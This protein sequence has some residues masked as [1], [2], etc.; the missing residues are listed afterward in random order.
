[1]PEDDSRIEEEFMAVERIL[2]PLDGSLTAE[3][4]LP[5]VRRLLRREDSELILVRAVVP[6]PVEHAALMVEAA[7]KA[8]EEYLEGIRARFEKAGVDAE[9]VVRLGSPGSVILDVARERKATLVAIATHGSSGVKRLLLGSVAED[10]VRHSPVPILAVR[11]FFEYSLAA[12]D[13]GEFDPVGTILF[14]VDEV[15]LAAIAIAPVSRLAEMFES[16]VT[17]VKVL[18]SKG[19]KPASEGAEE[20]ARKDLGSV[21]KR[22]GK[23]G[24][25]TRVEVLRGSAVEGI[26]GAATGADLIVMPTHGRS[27]LKRLFL[28]SVTEEVLRAARVPVLIVRPVKARS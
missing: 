16:R 26:L 3:K 21:A 11:P 27:G 6:P 8:A 14:P 15:A 24:V 28:G 4:V 7:Q 23:R 2:V 9:V 12:K 19:G 20:A 10:L 13:G 17:L 18:P 25:E 5:H 22:I 1:L